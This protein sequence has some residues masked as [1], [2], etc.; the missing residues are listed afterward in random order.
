MFRTSLHVILAATAGLLVSPPSPAAATGVLLSPASPAAA[1]GALPSSTNPAASAVAL[2][3]P[4]SPA[5]TAGALPSFTSPAAAEDVIPKNAQHFVI[6]SVAAKQGDS[7]RW[8][9]ADGTRHNRESMTMRGMSWEWRFEGRADGSGVPAMMKVTG[10]IPTGNVEETFTTNNGEAKWRSPVDEGSAPAAGR[11]YSANSGPI[12][13][14]AWLLEQLIASPSRQIDLLP[15][16]T[17]RA[18]HLGNLVVGTGATRQTIDLWTLTGLNATPQ[19]FWTDQQRRFF[20]MTAYGYLTWLPEAYVGEANKMQAF[21]AAAS[22]KKSMELAKTLARKPATPVAFTHVRMFDADN[23]QFLDDQTVIVSNQTIAAVGNAATTTI[24]PRAEIIDSRGMTLT[25]GLW[26]AHKHASDDYSGIQSLAFGVTSIRDPGN[27]DK[28]SVDRRTR[29]A[30]GELLFP[31]MYLSS[32]IDGKGP[33]TAQIANV[34]TSEEEAIAHVRR[35]KA[36]DFDG[37]KIYGSFDPRWLPATIAEAHKLGL[38]VHGHLPVGLRPMDVIKAGYDEITHINWLI[39]QGMP[40]DV[41]K[42][43]NS[44]LRVE[45]PGRYA[46]DLDLDS[47]AFKELI[48][49]MAAKRIYAD[50]TMVVFEG[51][52]A[53]EQGEFSTAAI[54]YLGTMPTSTERALRIGGLKVPNGLTRADYRASWQ[55]MIELL[56][57]LHRAGVP[58]VAGTDSTGFELVHELEIYQQAGFT[59]AEALATATIVP[60]RLVGQNA[61]TGSIKVGKV[62]DLLLVEGNPSVRIGDLRHTRIVMLEGLLLNADELRTQAG[63]TGRPK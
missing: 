8:T 54:P 55:K 12:E 26:D 5:A 23:L 11:F 9:A 25:P 53:T 30:A 43:S 14:T 34:A 60:A 35:A 16:G 6:S 2:L 38:H 24:P 42:H 61:R 29:R 31:H 21:S 13:S 33:Y 1:A 45:G 22:R 62:A 41:V 32:M 57:R 7:W 59:P 19:L 20:S 37:V 49:T 44:I 18:E 39:M 47:P 56:G 4:A 15:S 27:D 28:K 51:L 10:T 58:I 48:G 40:E 36:N 46:K 52:I 63:F 17:A 3:S 50:P